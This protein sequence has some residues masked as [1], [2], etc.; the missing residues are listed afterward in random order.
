MQQQYQLVRVKELT[1]GVESIVD[2]DWKN[3]ECVKLWLTSKERFVNIWICL[4]AFP[5]YFIKTS[6]AAFF[7]R[8]S[9]DRCWGCTLAWW[10]QC[11]NSIL[12]SWD[13]NPLLG[14]GSSRAHF[15]GCQQEVR[16]AS[17]RCMMRSKIQ[18]TNLTYLPKW[19]QINPWESSLFPTNYQ[20]FS[21]HAWSLAII[22]CVI[23]DILIELLSVIKRGL[24]SPAWLQLHSPICSPRQKRDDT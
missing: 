12:P 8:S 17:L 7:H 16:V 13:N 24:T 10:K 14:I 5:Q 21:S 18:F 2:V 20:L 6:Q 3:P 23:A 19:D 4:P 15:P 9:G 11:G 22:I 1:K